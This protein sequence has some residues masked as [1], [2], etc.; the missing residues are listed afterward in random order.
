[1]DIQNILLILK[2]SSR[3]FRN[4]DSNIHDSLKYFEWFEKELLTVYF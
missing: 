2:T 4:G 3:S 1:M